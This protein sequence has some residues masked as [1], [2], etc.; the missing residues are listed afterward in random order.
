LDAGSARKYYVRSLFGARHLSSLPAVLF[1]WNLYSFT[2]YINRIRGYQADRLK[3][4]G[5]GQGIIDSYYYALPENKMRMREYWP[6]S[7]AVYAREFPIS[8]RNIDQGI[9]ELSN[10]TPY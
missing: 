5:F 1:D 10:P 3:A 2:A 9:E 8:W 7:G 4:P 6:V